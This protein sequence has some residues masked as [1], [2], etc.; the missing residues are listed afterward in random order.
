MLYYAGDG[1]AYAAHT[2]IEMILRNRTKP[3]E[4]PNY[5][6]REEQVRQAFK[7]QGVKTI[8]S[9]QQKTK[10]ADAEVIRNTEGSSLSSRI[11][12]ASTLTSDEFIQRNRGKLS[13]KGHFAP[14]NDEL[15]QRF[16]KELAI[17]RIVG[18]NDTTVQPL[19][20]LLRTGRINANR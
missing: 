19:I 20:S 1:T 7:E 14:K 8:R 6:L 12:K 9:R 5:S 3:T 13:K 16:R 18:R 10:L 11:R 2:G 4:E 17:R 15:V